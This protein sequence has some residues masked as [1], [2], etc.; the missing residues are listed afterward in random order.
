MTNFLVSSAG[1]RGALVGILKRVANG[2]DVTSTDSSGLSAAGHLSDHFEIVPCVDSPE[3]I[4]VIQIAQR[5]EVDVWAPSVRVAEPG[6][7]K[8]RL[9]RNDK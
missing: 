9:E 5:H 8:W 7:D 6:F 2:G 1:R 3:F 4:D